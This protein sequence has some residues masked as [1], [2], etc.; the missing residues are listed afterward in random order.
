MCDFI[1]NLSTPRKCSSPL[2]DARGKVVRVSRILRI[3]GAIER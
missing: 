1:A 2:V 3:T